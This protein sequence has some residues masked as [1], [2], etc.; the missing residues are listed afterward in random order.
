MPMSAAI[1]PGSVAQVDNLIDEHGYKIPAPDDTSIKVASELDPSVGGT[2][3]TNWWRYGL[4]A[5]AI[6]AAI[7]LTMQ[8][9]GGNKGTDVIPGTPVAAPQ[10]ETTGTTA[11]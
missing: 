4:V 2:G 1:K 8:M 3:P 7:L 9:L 10:T 6:V 5:L 11:P